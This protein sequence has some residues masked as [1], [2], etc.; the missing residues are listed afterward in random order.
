MP[1]P[2]AVLTYHSLDASGAVTS[3]N[4]AIFRCQMDWLAAS[5]TPVLPLR[6]IRQAHAGLALTFDDGYRNL[7]V[8]AIPILAEKGFPATFFVNSS[9]A[10]RGNP[11]LDWSALREAASAG[12]EIG[13]HGIEH[14]D[15]AR[16]PLTQAIDQLDGCRRAI[17]DRLGVPVSTCAYPFGRST[18]P[19][20]DWARAAFHLSC[21]TRLRYLGSDD[22]TA[23]LPRLDVYY[24]QSMAWFRRVLRPSGQAWLQLRALLRDARA[25]WSE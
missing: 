16:V 18:P 8:H 1:A 15:L 9:S 24:L 14:L 3:L 17:E 11:H 5:N 12:I 6:Q 21:G 4:P 25:H 19:L 22:D 7:L 10:D 13:S 2:K 20:R 23:D